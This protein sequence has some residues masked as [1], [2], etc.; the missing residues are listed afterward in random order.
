MLR[1]RTIDND[2]RIVSSSRAAAGTRRRELLSDY[3][4][5]VA[6]A[7]GSNGPAISDPC[8][9]TARAQRQAF[10]QVRGE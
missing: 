5:F 6:V 8:L 9:L 1:L 7:H 4:I 10:C 3:E 2:A